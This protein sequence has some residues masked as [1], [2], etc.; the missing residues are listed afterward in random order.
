MPNRASEN[1]EPVRRIGL[2]D[3]V[4]LAFMVA[5]FL[6]ASWYRSRGRMFWGDE[7]M[8]WIVIRQDTWPH[9]MKMWGDGI[10]SS[11]FFFYVFGRPW[12][13]LFGANELSLRMFS[14]F[15]MALCF[16]LT[17]LS[18]RRT[19]RIEVVAAVL[20]IVFFL[21]RTALWQ[22]ANGRIYGVLMASVGLTVYALL[23]T[24][25][26]EPDA[27]AW[28]P[29]TLT[30]VAFL[31][32]TG[33]HTL[34]MLYWGVFF[35]GLLARDLCFRVFRPKLYLAALAGLIVVP[36]SWHNIVSTAALGKPTYWTLRPTAR[37]LLVGI[38]DYSR[39]TELFLLG[40]ATL[41]VVAFLMRSKESPITLVPRSKISLYIVLGSFLLMLLGMFAVS[42]LGT[43]IF[44]DRYLLPMAVADVL[45]ICE[46][47]SR[48]AEMLHTSER[49]QRVAAGVAALVFAGIY[50]ADLRFQ[51]PLPVHDYA[52]ALLAAI[53]PGEPIVVTS[54]GYFVEMTFY[55]NQDR[56]LL[57][58]IDWPVQLDPGFGPGGASGLHEMDNWKTDGFYAAQIQ[59]TE[60]ILSGN[61]RF[62]VV[63][64]N[65]H[66]LW[67][68]RR[69]A[70]NPAYKTTELP[71]YPTTDGSLR[72]WQVETR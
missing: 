65:L 51:A 2:A 45:L 62:V 41:C 43:S 9:L 63:S 20:P 8:G 33:S 19:N 60:Q 35:A 47:F 40:A 56:E 72:I 69:I 67:F 25:P 38:G 58:P 28:W 27:N 23:R 5:L 57:T 59:P 32:L 55:H 16:V 10:D 14:A 12:L 6:F 39:K 30:F 49:T 66:T 54:V 46:L 70:E 36:V 15:G 22:L 24:S 13:G 71:S 64:D 34:G 21:N 29:T 4:L 18:A 42:R 50:V 37:D 61:R 7:I 1:T 26:E 11:G 52:P 53:P 44:V 31:L 17:W 3:V 68:R 48:A